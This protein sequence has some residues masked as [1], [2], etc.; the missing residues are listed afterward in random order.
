MQDEATMPNLDSLELN[1]EPVEISHEFEVDLACMIVANHRLTLEAITRQEDH[2]LENIHKDPLLDAD[3][4]GSFM[5]YVQTGYDDRRRAANNLALVALVTRFHH[6]LT[7]L[8]RRL[9]AT[10]NPYS[11]QSVPKELS[12]LTS[13][14]GHGPVAPLTFFEDLAE[15]RHSIIHADAQA[16]WEY[17]GVKRKVAD[18]YRNAWS[19]VEIS[20]EQLTEA[21]AKAIEQVK[22]YDDKLLRG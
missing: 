16:E 7:R 12:I 3:E 14:L 17:G 20:E 5:S 11:Q 22:W 13:A 15:V 8:I 18:S 6:W 2:E 10:A 21:V 19:E 4:L 9:P 1:D